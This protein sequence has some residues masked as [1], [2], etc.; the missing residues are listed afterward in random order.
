MNPFYKTNSPPH[1]QNAAYMNN[2]RE[3][4]LQVKCIILWCAKTKEFCEGDVNG[5]KFNLIA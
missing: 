3:V 4:K 1:F 2:I 5:L